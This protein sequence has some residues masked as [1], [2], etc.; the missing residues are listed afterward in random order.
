MACETDGQNQHH[1]PLA[2]SATP[3][4]PGDDDDTD[5]EEEDEEDDDDFH[6]VAGDL[7][8]EMEEALAAETGDPNASLVGALVSLEKSINTQCQLMNKRLNKDRWALKSAADATRAPVLGSALPKVATR[9]DKV[10][11]L[12]V[13]FR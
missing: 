7:A 11:L 9:T 5:E 6:T 4:K 13:C 3:H 12:D 8:T 1:Q 2:W 10:S